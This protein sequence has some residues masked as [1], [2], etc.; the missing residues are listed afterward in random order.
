MIERI[1]DAL[2]RVGSKAQ[3]KLRFFTTYATTWND[4]VWPRIT[5]R[6]LV[7]DGYGKHAIVF[8]CVQLY[9]RVMKEAPLL[10]YQ[11]DDV[12]EKTADARHPARRVLR[13]PNRH[14]SEREFWSYVVTYAAVGGLVCIW[15]ER[16]RRGEVVG[17]WPLHRGQ[18]G[19]IPS[20]TGWLRGWSFDPGDGRPVFI[21]PEDVIPWRWAIDPNNPLDALPVLFA[22][23]R[24]VDTGAEAMRYVFAFLKNDASPRTALV[25]KGLL[26]EKVKAAMLEQ[27]RQQYG[28]DNRGMPMI[29]EGQEAS[30][31]RIG[32]NLNELASEALHGVPDAWITAAYGVPAVLIGTSGGLQRAIQGAPSEMAAYFVES[33]AVPMWADIADAF[34]VHLLWQDF[35]GEDSGLIMAFDLTQVR[36]LQEDVTAKRRSTLEGLRM[37]LLTV[38][39]ARI[40]DGRDPVP[41]GD[42]FLQ[43]A[44]MAE[45]PLGGSTALTPSA[46]L[47]QEDEPPDDEPG[48]KALPLPREVEIDEDDIEDAIRLWD[49]MMADRHPELVGILDARS[50]NKRR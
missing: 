33:V 12:G 36:A 20:E 50:T 41:G 1:R 9:V 32:S 23:A 29:L 28:G 24:A 11:E 7:D 39:E 47:Q 19:P 14:M 40:E 13:R 31:E 30:L 16:N 48:A 27:F 25:A 46:P 42:V 38:N 15:K 6:R 44:G 21:P 49:T 22:I 45:I 2:Q 8:A 26:P 34:T 43:P 4:A 10:V 17:L 18:I 5:F 35:G 3:E 37:R